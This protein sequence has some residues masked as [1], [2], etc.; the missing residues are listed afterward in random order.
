MWITITSWTGSR[1]DN[2]MTLIQDWQTILDLSI[3]SR[4]QLIVLS[5]PTLE[6]SIKEFK[7]SDKSILLGQI[8]DQVIYEMNQKDQIYS[9]LNKTDTEPEPQ[10]DTVITKTLGRPVITW[11][12]LLSGIWFLGTEDKPLPPHI[13]GPIC[14][15]CP[16]TSWEN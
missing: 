7:K 6:I 8:W 3:I 4:I 16:P 1:T 5:Y 13:Q 12:M 2:L 15:T 14:Q 10:V 9:P 11:T